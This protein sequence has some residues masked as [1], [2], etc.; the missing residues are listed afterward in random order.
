MSPLLNTILFMCNHLESGNLFSAVKFILIVLY[1]PSEMAGYPTLIVAILKYCTDR[2]QSVTKELYPSV[3]RQLG[4]SRFKVEKDIRDVINKGWQRRD[5]KTW[6]PYFPQEKTPTNLEFIS[7]I[8]E[9]IDMW[10][11]CVVKEE[12][13]VEKK[14]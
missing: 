13:G 8:A 6:D 11:E 12:M 3:G 2:T 14:L 4:V 9:V 5:R 7:R 10:Q 1:M